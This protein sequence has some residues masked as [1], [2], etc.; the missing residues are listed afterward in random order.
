MD[1]ISAGFTR[2][3]LSRVVNRC[4]A[5]SDLIIFSSQ[6]F[7]KHSDWDATSLTYKKLVYSEALIN[8]HPSRFYYTVPVC[9]DCYRI[10]TLMD[11][12]R[13]VVLFHRPDVYAISA[14]EKATLRKRQT[15]LDAYSALLVKEQRE[16]RHRKEVENWNAA[17]ELEAT[18]ENDEDLQDNEDDD[19]FEYGIHHHGHCGHDTGAKIDPKDEDE[20]E[21]LFPNIDKGNKNATSSNPLV[22]SIESD[23]PIEF[24]FRRRQLEETSKDKFMKRMDKELEKKVGSMPS[25]GRASNVKG[26][27]SPTKSPEKG[28]PSPSKS[29]D[30]HPRTHLHVM[31]S[32]VQRMQ[33]SMPEQPEVNKY[34][35]PRRQKREENYPETI[36]I[37]TLKGKGV[38]KDEHVYHKNAKGSMAS[39]A[40]ILKESQADVP[41]THK[42]PP[43]MGKKWIYHGGKNS[44]NQPVMRKSTNDLG[45]GREVRRSKSAG[46]SRA[47]P[48]VQ[49]SANKE[50]IVVGKIRP[51]SAVEA[52]SSAMGSKKPFVSGSKN[53]QVSTLPSG[54]LERHKGT[55]QV[56]HNATRPTSSKTGKDYKLLPLNKYT[57]ENIQ[58]ESEKVEDAIRRIERKKM[59]EQQKEW[60]KSER[61]QQRISPERVHPTKGTSDSWRGTVIRTD[62]KYVAGTDSPFGPA[63]V[64]E[65]PISKE[66]DTSEATQ[67]PKKNFQSRNEIQA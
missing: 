32:T 56:Y 3:Q 17:L 14:D 26:I 15:Y 16:E 29:P 52:V 62:N 2:C 25:R 50:N 5:E 24:D 1:Q 12:H 4:K 46:T 35:K 11:Q 37:D 13:E 28:V 51:K 67:R 43:H 21:D 18:S 39:W 65:L 58:Q 40:R 33:P 63:P 34:H 9:K 66:N 41:Q 31:E 53:V 23:G 60:A 54:A 10:Y 36:V 45:S 59:R 38:S 48:S 8:V 7:E 19:L 61:E 6:R 64:F 55:L 44:R 20:D 22:S 57:T 47:K 30:S 42:H 49:F 27:I